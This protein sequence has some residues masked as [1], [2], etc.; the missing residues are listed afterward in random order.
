MTKNDLMEL[1][2]L[3]V[4]TDPPYSL[5]ELC[6]GYYSPYY[7]FM[8]LV[9]KEM[10]P[11]VAVELGVEKGRGIAS[12]AGA[13][14]R[15]TVVG[16]DTWSTPQID[17]ARDA[18]PNFTF[19]HAASLPVPDGVPGKIDILHIDTEHSYSM[20]RG[21]FEAY[22][23]RLSDGA[24]VLFDDLH[25]AED[26]VLRYFEELPYEKFQDDR[27]HPVCGYGVVLI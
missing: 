9:A 26:D 10:A 14:W 21:E 19:I 12:V 13:S 18:F 3:A 25:A 27:L 5:R 7:H 1:A 17:A 24:V 20:V 4:A 11:C 8:H 2:D 6:G 22:K 23:S 15:N 16:V